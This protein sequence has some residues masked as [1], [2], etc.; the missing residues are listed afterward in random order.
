MS[1]TWTTRSCGH[2]AA[3]LTVPLNQQGI[4]RTTATTIMNEGAARLGC[5]RSRLA[6][7]CHPT[8]PPGHGVDNDYAISGIP[9]AD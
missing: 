5:G 8:H 4:R 1:A 2:V 6:A 3:R 9:P 7:T